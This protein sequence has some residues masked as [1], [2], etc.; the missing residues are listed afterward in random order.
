MPTSSRRKLSGQP[1]CILPLCLALLAVVTIATV[2]VAATPPK[3][4]SY[5]LDTTAGPKGAGFAVSTTPQADLNILIGSIV[6]TIL[7]LTGV[8]F[9]LFIIA[10]GDMWM[11][12][13][14]NEEKMKK[15][16]DMI[17]NS[18]VG[19]AIAFSAYMSADFIVALVLRVAGA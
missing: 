18:V 9:M 17:F 15:A 4:P 3:D 7:G 16:R 19:L 6:K 13:G 14:G 1:G 10:A 8:I 5:G 11:T 12:S 2:A